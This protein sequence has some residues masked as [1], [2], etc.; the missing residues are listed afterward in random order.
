MPTANI[1]LSR[2]SRNSNRWEISVP[3]ARPPGSPGSFMGWYWIGCVHGG[4]G[5]LARRTTIRRLRYDG[6]GRRC[7]IVQRGGGGRAGRAGAR[8]VLRFLC[9]HL[10][11]PAVFSLSIRS[12]KRRARARAAH[13]VADL[14]GEVSAE[15]LMKAQ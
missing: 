6:V 5:G 2:R 11:S 3:S 15:E 12:Q 8:L 13:P 7:G 14:A 9:S 4:R 10:I 1:A